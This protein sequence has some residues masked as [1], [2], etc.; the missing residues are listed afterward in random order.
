MEIEAETGKLKRG[1]VVNFGANLNLG[2]G[3]TKINNGPFFFAG[4]AKMV[5]GIN[6]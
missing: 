3:L 4:S 5:Q 6:Y 1:K 2:Y